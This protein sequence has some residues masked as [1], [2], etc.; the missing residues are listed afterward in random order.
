M[1][2]WTTQQAQIK[3][4]GNVLNEE[5]LAFNRREIKRCLETVLRFM[6]IILGFERLAAASLCVNM[7][8]VSQSWIWQK[9][10][11]DTIRN[12]K[13]CQNLVNLSTWLQTETNHI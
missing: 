8:C 11:V 2:D 9:N 3:R 4:A 5:N 6:A 7:R 10:C 1:Q 13:M 12:F